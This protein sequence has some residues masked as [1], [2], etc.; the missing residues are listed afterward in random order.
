MKIVFFIDQ[1][2][3]L[4]PEMD[5]L[6]FLLAF[7]QVYKALCEEMFW[8]TTVKLAE[9]MTLECVY[10]SMDTL[11]Q[12]EWFK[13][14][15]TE[16]ESIA[17]F[18]PT[19]GVIIREPYAGRVDFLNATPPPNDMTLS[20]N[21][22]SDADVGFYSCSLHTFP[23]GPWE[24]V[25]RVVPSESFEKAVPSNS[26]M[27]SERGK[28]ITL[29]CQLP[30]KWSV[31]QVMWEKI[32]PHQIDLLTSCNLSQGRGHISKYRRQILSSCHQGMGSMSITVPHLVAS[33]SGLYRCSLQASTGEG[34]GF[35]VRLTVTDGKTDNQYILFVAGGTVLL[36]LFVILITTIIVISYNRRR[37]RQKRG[38]FEESWNIQNKASN[39]YRSPVSTNQPSDGAT[40]DVYV[41][42]PTFSRRPKARV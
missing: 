32:Q 15:T 33:D 29:T 6:T 36:L 42:Y 21:N 18:S 12:M 34:E 14:N 11:T 35:V 40:E 30:V 26:H 27:V 25:I 17:I 23:H 31:Q 22:A 39:N 37:P 41:N 16:K 3:K 13:I 20:F 10:P 4:F 9:N 1:P 19:Y 28:N 38:L 8:D 7:L 2:P 24:K 5:Y